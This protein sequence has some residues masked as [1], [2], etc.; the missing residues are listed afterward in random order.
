MSAMWRSLKS[1]VQLPKS[2]LQ[3]PK[4]RELRRHHTQYATRI[5]HQVSRFTLLPPVAAALCLQ[6]DEQ[7]HAG[8]T[9]VRDALAGLLAARPT[10]SP[11]LQVSAAERGG[12]RA[13]LSSARSEKHTS[14]LQS[15]RHLV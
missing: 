3:H 14:E 5:T 12:G 7:A 8:Y 6:P 1:E 9:S 15:L 2:K 11:Q 4:P 10:S 13:G